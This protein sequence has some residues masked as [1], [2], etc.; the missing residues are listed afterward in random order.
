MEP[1]GPTSGVTPLAIG[2][3]MLADDNVPPYWA[4]GTDPTINPCIPMALATPLPSHPLPG[5]VMYWLPCPSA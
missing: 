2:N 5:K 4:G 3:T 1:S